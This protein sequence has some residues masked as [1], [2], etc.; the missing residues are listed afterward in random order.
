MST[1][2]LPRRVLIAAF[3]TLLALTSATAAELAGFKDKLFAYPGILEQADD[4]AFLKIDYDKMRDIHKRDEIPERRVKGQYVSLGVRWRQDF[5]TVEH[6]GR[7]VDVF[8]IG[9]LNS[10]RFAVIFVHGRGGDR[11]L[12]ANDFTFGGNFNRLKNL[13][14]EN[15]GVYFAPSAKDFGDRGA[16]DVSALVDFVHASAPQAKIVLTCASMGTSICWKITN[17]ATVSGQLSGMMIFGGPTDSAFPESAAYA[18]K[19]PMFFSHGSDDNVY[20]WQDQYALYKSLIGKRYPTR[21]VLFN[22]GSHGTPIRMT[23]WRETLN[24]ILK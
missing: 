11:K 20:A 14:D 16:A 2:R 4:G 3:S 5:E 19:L 9:K 1:D 24:W 10:A 18:E 17:D 13:A 6:Q 15:G 21:F 7:S 8:R 22:T 12:G 23:D